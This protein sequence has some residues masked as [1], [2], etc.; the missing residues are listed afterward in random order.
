MLQNNSN[1]GGANQ[2]SPN[3]T[4]NNPSSSTI[5]FPSGRSGSGAQQPN[6]HIWLP[7]HKPSDTLLRLTKWTLAQ[8][9]GASASNHGRHSF[10]LT[11]AEPF[12]NPDPP[13]PVLPASDE[14]QL[15]QQAADL[16]AKAKNDEGAPFEEESLAL[17]R[18]LQERAL[19]E[20]ERCWSKLKKAGIRTASLTKA[21][22]ANA[23]SGG[24][25]TGVQK[26]S[27]A[28]HLIELAYSEADLFTSTDGQPYAA[29]RQG[30]KL[31]TMPLRGRDSLESWLRHRYFEETNSAV[32]NSKLQE[33]LNTIEMK[34]AY[35]GE[36]RKVWLR[37]GEAD[38]KFYIDLGAS[39]YRAVE[40]DSQG[41]R[42]VD[43][44]PVH[45]RRTNS[46]KPLPEP[47]H[48]GS[49]DKLWELLNLQDQQ[50]RILVTA[51]LVAALRPKGPFPLLILQ[52]EQGSGKSTTSRFLRRFTDPSSVDN[53]QRPEN[54][55]DMNAAGRQSWVIIYDNLSS[56]NQTVS[57]ALCVFST[58]GGFGARKLFT[59]HDEE[60]FDYQRPLIL[61]GI[62]RLAKRLDLQDRSI[63]IEMPEILPAKR[64][65]E[66]ELDKCFA[67]AAPG[68]MGSLLDAL[69][70]SL[71][72]NTVAPPVTL[73]RMADFARAI[74]AAEPALPWSPGEFLKAYRQNHNEAVQHDLHQE[75]LVDL[76]ADVIPFTGTA[77]ELLELLNRNT[78]TNAVRK[79]ALPKVPNKLSEAIRRLTPG[80]R[81]LGIE[82]TY[83]HTGRGANKKR[84]LQ[85]KRIPV[86][87]ETTEMQILS[88]ALQ[89]HLPDKTNR[90]RTKEPATTNH[91][92]G[93]D[94]PHAPKPC[95]QR[96]SNDGDDGDDTTA[97]PDVTGNNVAESSHP[98]ERSANNVD[99]DGSSETQPSTP[100]HE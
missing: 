32:P 3:T 6:E 95:K 49:L 59:N 48:G 4:S 19:P 72:R 29:V 93:D 86:D 17:L 16:V 26:S 67:E 38:G 97:P 37:T 89:L 27:T 53:R 12:K 65:T 50:H 70:A 34:C 45:F 71:N 60:V 35:C 83:S 63:I 43:T 77:T 73:P 100:R 15:V 41:W 1:I 39:D 96:L 36:R 75:P 91:Q 57:D 8:D 98:S 87:P 68:I 58:G 88:P 66:E 92:S 13:R 25:Q 55:R 46:M 9:D 82:C 54:I 69:S 21:L 80:L 61:N 76:L 5:E 90:G 11:A 42:I 79:R 24:R 74:I 62:D 18:R 14:E 10:N 30:A 52:G 84:C 28:N 56:I 78:S 81:K 99:D 47:A 40:V 22:K 2:A 51:W 64:Q 20:F 94:T 23:S 7:P 31:V 85:L 44:P 33:A